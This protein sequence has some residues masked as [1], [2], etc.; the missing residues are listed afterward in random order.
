M[1]EGPTI[2]ILKEETKHFEERKVLEV[3]G[4]VKTIDP[5]LLLNKKLLHIKTWGKH[6]LLCF[7]TFTIRIHFLLFGSYAI[8]KP[9]ERAEKLSLR[10][11]NGQI[12]FYAC[13]IKFLAG[14]PEDHY[15]W[16]GDVMNPAWDPI[17]AKHKI[18][19]HPDTLICDI[20]LN[21]EIFAGVGN[22]IKNEVLFRV[23]VQ[24]ASRTGA[25][26]GI[27]INQI[28]KEARDYSFDFLKWKKQFVLLKQWLIHTK[29]KCPKCGGL[30][31]KEYLGK[32]KRRCFYCKKDQKEY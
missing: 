4:N 12:F 29:K 20:L 8:D 25:I 26:S 13:S 14:S 21:Q 32:Q 11:T 5:E 31:I 10:F 6:Y 28:I 16:S 1:P 18:K 19:Q 27:K 3:T 17:Q 7:H 2:I 15:D 22:I 24:P 23:G 30:V 9:K